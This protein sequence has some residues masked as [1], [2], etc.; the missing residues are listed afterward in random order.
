MSSISIKIKKGVIT[1]IRIHF[2][3]NGVVIWDRNISEKLQGK[4]KK[5]R[6]TEGLE[7]YGKKFMCFVPEMGDLRIIISSRKDLSST[8]DGPHKSLK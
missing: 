1:L 2:I 5:E 7:L 4:K 8:K 6:T 3:L